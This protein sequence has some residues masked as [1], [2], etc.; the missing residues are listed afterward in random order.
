MYVY[1][2]MCVCVCVSMYMYICLYVVSNFKLVPPIPWS[3]KWQPTP[4][5]LHGKFYGQRSLMGYSPRGHKG[6]DTTEHAHTSPIPIQHQRVHPNSLTPHIFKYFLQWWEA[7][8]SLSLKYLLVW[9]VTYSNQSLFSSP[10]IYPIQLSCSPCCSCLL[11]TGRSHVFIL[12]HSALALMSQ[13]KTL[14]PVLPLP[15]LPMDILILC[16]LHNPHW[17]TL[18]L[19]VSCATH[20]QPYIWT[21][22]LTLSGPSTVH[23]APPPHGNPPHHS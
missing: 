9:F 23:L 4:I 11:K 2:Y 5:F 14:P 16:G 6:S 13:I 12:P 15:Q 1:I 7:W 10:F 3:R 8:L 18:I 19:P 20:C 21:P 17:G 22:S